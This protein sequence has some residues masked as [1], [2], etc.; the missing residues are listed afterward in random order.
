M[1]VSFDPNTQHNNPK[2]EHSI[3]HHNK[4][5]RKR[6]HHHHHHNTR[7]SNHRD[8]NHNDLHLP[9]PHNLQQRRPPVG[10]VLEPERTRATTR[11]T[12]PT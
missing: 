7:E 3:H 11:K 12:P 1:R 9:H 2:H 6:R 10:R 8:S 5:S 4:H